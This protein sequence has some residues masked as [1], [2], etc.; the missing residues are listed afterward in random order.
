MVKLAAE[1]QP[2]GRIQSVVLAGVLTFAVV[3]GGCGGAKSTTTVVSHTTTASTT[4]SPKP[5]GAAS[6]TTGP[7]RGSLTGADHAP[8]AG[9]KWLYSVKVTDAS[10]KP[11]SGS[12]DIEF[13]FAGQVVGRDS[14]P[15]H[16][17]KNGTWQDL[18]T[19]PDQAIGEPLT[20]QA[21]VHT[22]LGSITLDWPVA[23][24]R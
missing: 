17:V 16:P 15:T 10:G 23:V 19:F 4:T 21:V 3:L 24:K 8:A 9:K 20:L 6:V 7:V 22:S 18:L 1:V 13:L 11:L 2:R 12:V 14:P 5:S